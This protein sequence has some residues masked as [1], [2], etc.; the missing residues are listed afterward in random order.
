[1]D[2]FTIFLS[3]ICFPNNL[4]KKI[5][6]QDNALMAPN[7][8]PLQLPEVRPSPNVVQLGALD[9]MKLSITHQERSKILVLSAPHSPNF[10]I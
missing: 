10:E 3:W 5:L 6:A 2:Y 9:P 4:Y 7:T 1:M 8:I